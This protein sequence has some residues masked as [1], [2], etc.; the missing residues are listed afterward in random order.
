MPGAQF[1]NFLKNPEFVMKISVFG[2]GYVGFTSCCCMASEGHTVVGVDLDPSKVAQIN[3]GEVPFKEP[4]LPSLL[5][6]GE[7]WGCCMHHRCSDRL[8]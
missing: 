8:R 6:E 7:S 2:V 1:F 3:S 5:A 4:G